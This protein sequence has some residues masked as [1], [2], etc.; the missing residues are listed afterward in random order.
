LEGD[1]AFYGPKVDI[2]M[3]D[4]LGRSW[5]M[6]TIQLDFQQPRRFN[7]QY[8]AQDGSPQTPV[9]IHRVIYGSL[10]RFIGI[11]IEHF[12]GAFPT[13]LSPVQVKL[14]PIADD[15]H[16]YAAEILNLLKQQGIRAEL[17][18]RSER[19]QAKIRDAQLEK[20]PYMLVIGKKE[21]ESK[22]VAVRTRNEVDLGAMPV[23]K[24]VELV[25]QEI[26]SK[27]LNLLS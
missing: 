14:L 13:W 23:S 21:V 24:F 1:G 7:L 25:K 4:A 5:Q 18:D 6:G 8:V 16:V 10:E 2:L 3:K 19:L 12:A 11:I 20:V 22:Q 17:D 9:A 15:Q 27:N 26:D